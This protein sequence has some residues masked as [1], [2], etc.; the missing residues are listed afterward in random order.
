MMYLIM[1]GVRLNDKQLDRLSD[2]AANAGLVVLAAVLVPLILGDRVGFAL[3][4]QALLLTVISLVISLT[5][6]RT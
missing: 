3:L 2:F 4:A 5:L 6:L 1:K